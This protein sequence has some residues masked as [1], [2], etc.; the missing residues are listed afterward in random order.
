MIAE[1]IAHKP[2][3]DM[4]EVTFWSDGVDIWR[5]TG[6]FV[7]LDT[8]GLPMG[9]RWECAATQWPRVR[10]VLYAWAADVG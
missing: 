6:P 3:D 8:Y 1:A 5:V 10:G 2:V 4:P 9:R 7:G